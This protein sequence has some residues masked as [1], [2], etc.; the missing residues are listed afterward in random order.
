MFGDR[1][2]PIPQV[3]KSLPRTES[4]PHGSDQGSTGRMSL[5]AR[6]PS[7]CQVRSIQTAVELADGRNKARGVRDEGRYDCKVLQLKL[8]R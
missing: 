1:Q 8:F 5:V 4:F 2:L 6:A 3:G 7:S